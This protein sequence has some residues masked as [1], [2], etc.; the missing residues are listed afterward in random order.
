MRGVYYLKIL[1]LSLFLT[2]IGSNV[3]NVQGASITKYANNIAKK[4]LMAKSLPFED[5]GKWE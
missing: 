5:C 1:L 4:I 2:L 3:S